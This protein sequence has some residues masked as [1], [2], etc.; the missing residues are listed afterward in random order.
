MS[1]IDLNHVQQLLAEANSDDKAV[2]GRALEQ[3]VVHLFETIPGVTCESTDV[4]DELHSQE[5]DV[6]F[7]NEGERGALPHLPHLLIVECKN[8]ARAVGSPEVTRFSHKIRDRGEHFGILVTK[9]GITGADE[10][11]MQAA[12]SDLVIE[13]THGRTIIVFEERELAKVKSGKRLAELVMNKWRAFKTRRGLYWASDQEL[14]RPELRT[15]IR[16]AI[17][18]F[19]KD[20]VDQFLAAMTETSDRGQAIAKMHGVAN[21][22]EDAVALAHTD[23]DDPFWSKPRAV[24][25]EFGGA[26]ANL[27]LLDEKARGTDAE[28]LE[29]AA[30]VYGPDRM[31]AFVGGELWRTLVAY[32]LEQVETSRELDSYFASL[33]L[34]QLAIDQIG[35][36][37][38]IEPGFDDA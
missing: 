22:V 34:V 20:A 25:I 33:A 11:Q 28:S 9:R 32:Y 17:R 10:A 36:L 4:V 23:A 1:D 15:G 5:I 35:Q 37:D 24:L 18:A 26:A 29:I 21:R 27:V 16:E 7:L 30:D 2:K 14:E 12:Y 31:H 8:W 19:R 6:F 13:Q 3:L 38:A